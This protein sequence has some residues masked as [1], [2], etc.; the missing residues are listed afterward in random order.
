LLNSLLVLLAGA[1]R[2]KKPGK[3]V[4]IGMDGG[5]DK[6]FWGWGHPYELLPLL[7]QANSQYELSYNNA[8]TEARRAELVEYINPAEPVEP[9]A[10]QSPQDWM[11]C[12][13]SNKHNVHPFD[14]KGLPNQL[15][16]EK[17]LAYDLAAEVERN[18]NVHKTI[19]II[20]LEE[21]FGS[22]L[23]RKSIDESG[24]FKQQMKTF[25]E[26]DTKYIA[27]TK[28]GKYKTMVSRLTV[29]N[30]VVKSLVEHKQKG[31]RLG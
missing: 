19:N 24:S 28:N 31:G 4:F 26:S 12:G 27:V 5:I 20:R 18:E 8:L 23:Y 29:L 9:G 16:A 3:V 25:F 14:E 22:V 1:V 10:G 7:L 2:Q 15:F 21:L 13:L 17:F 30:S 6:C 11:R